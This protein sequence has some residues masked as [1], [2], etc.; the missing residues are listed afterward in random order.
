MK[1]LILLPIITANDMMRYICILM[2]IF[3]NIW[4]FCLQ[5][6]KANR[7]LWKIL[8]LIHY[9]ILQ[10]VIGITSHSW[11]L[12]F[13]IAIGGLLTIEDLEH[14]EVASWKLLILFILSII[15][16]CNDFSVWKIIAAVLFTLG[17]IILQFIYGGMLGTAD[18]IYIACCTFI[19]GPIKTVYATCI[20]CVLSI[21][22]VLPTI[23]QNKETPIPFLPGLCAGVL[24][25]VLFF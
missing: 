1:G 11:I 15:S 6:E 18:I 3:I 19:L 8:I 17:L 2:F 16:L 14:M 22:A 7:K 23:K 10:S 4:S 13:A 5:I 25:T 9:C 21:L 12:L 24:Y 20:G